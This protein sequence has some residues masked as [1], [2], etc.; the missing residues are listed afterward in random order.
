M[1]EDRLGA[2]ARHKERSSRTK[3]AID[4]KAM[5]DG[6]LI[7]RTDCDETGSYESARGKEGARATVSDL[8]HEGEQ[9]K[10]LSDLDREIEELETSLAA[11]TSFLEEREET[12]YGPAR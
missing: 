3:L 11:A 1:N 7:A 9:E 4:Y 5:N 8:G 2:G 12:A 6:R 10:L